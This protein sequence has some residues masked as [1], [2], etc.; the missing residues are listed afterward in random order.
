MLGQ[1]LRLSKHSAI[2]GF[3]AVASQAVS[4][5]LIP[6]YS[7]Y[8]DPTDYGVLEIF[9]TTLTVLG[10]IA[11]LG[12]WQGLFRHFFDYD[13]EEKRRTA[14]GTAFLF[15]LA[16]CAAF[17]LSLVF[18]ADSIA[19][20]LFDSGDYASYFKVTFATLFLDGLVVIVL[21]VI[22]ARQESKKYVLI[23]LGR[24]LT[25][26]ALKLFFVIVLRRSVLGILEAELISVSLIFVTLLPEI[27]KSVGLRFS[28]PVLRSMLSFGLPLVPSNL[29]YWAV[30]MSDRYFL[31]FLST[32]E[33]LGLYSMG[34]KFGAAMQVIIVAPLQLAWSQLI[35][36]IAKEK[37][38]KEFYSRSLTYYLL[39]GTFAALALSVLSREILMAR[40]TPPF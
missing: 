39:L 21:S 18:A 40:T 10:L 23:T 27:V 12:L 3:G 28:A 32:S 25:S 38:A 19:R 13:T 31:Q 4:F 20:L 17:S 16:F 11:T 24:F 34:A 8:L 7:R 30:T 5:L 14:I 35:F 26:V 2:Y 1:L 22:R 29:A 33:E 15:S 9:Q 36:S 6:V 37:N